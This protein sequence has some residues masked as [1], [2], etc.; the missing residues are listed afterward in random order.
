MIAV[1][2]T[3]ML[4]ISGNGDVIEPDEG[5]VAIGSGVWP[6]QARQ[7]PFSIRPNWMC[8]GLSRSP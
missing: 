6:A 7:R 1:D 5:I 3:S 8:A 4:L 2:D